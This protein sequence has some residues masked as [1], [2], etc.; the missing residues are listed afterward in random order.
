MLCAAN[1]SRLDAY[2]KAHSQLIG[3]R[4]G[5][6]SIMDIAQ[7]TIGQIA[8]GRIELSGPDIEVPTKM[9]LAAS[10]AFYELATNAVK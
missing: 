2:A 1:D 6:A 10:M 7:D 3:S 5:Q 4:W 8:D 9:A